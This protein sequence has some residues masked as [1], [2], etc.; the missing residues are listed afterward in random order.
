MNRKLSAAV[1]KSPLWQSYRI[2]RLLN[3]I[4]WFLR[5]TVAGDLAAPGSL[6]KAC[7]D[8][9][10]LAD[11]LVK[12]EK[13]FPA[14]IR[15]VVQAVLDQK[16]QWL[17][18]QRCVEPVQGLLWRLDNA[19]IRNN[20]FL[21]TPSYYMLNLGLYVDQVVHP[22]RKLSLPIH[23]GHISE[24]NLPGRWPA[25][26]LWNKIWGSP[27]NDDSRKQLKQDLEKESQYSTIIH[28]WWHLVFYLI[29]KSNLTLPDSPVIPA[30]QDWASAI[31]AC[32]KEIT[33]AIAGGPLLAGKTWTQNNVDLELESLRTHCQRHCGLPFN[34]LTVLCKQGN[35]AAIEK[36]LRVF[37]HVALMKRLR[38]K[39]PGFL[40]RSKV[41][42]SI[43][44][45][46]PCLNHRGRMR[47]RV[48]M[49]S[50]EDKAVSDWQQEHHEQL[51]NLPSP[52]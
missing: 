25:Q 49:S 1:K 47:K 2:G 52:D 17:P 46:L 11:K 48:S 51:Q 12:K 6:E 9:N 31:K 45:D 8:F 36:A 43:K 41:Y 27:L 50:A 34:R 44:D 23:S 39:S 24:S 40:G 22:V 15:K 42:K 18:P 28:L 4:E 26:Q 37:S 13:A 30:T 5:M 33:R 3:T 19:L 21:Y 16:K 20:S 35:S 38:L 7:E 14:E 32:E 10:E 29:E